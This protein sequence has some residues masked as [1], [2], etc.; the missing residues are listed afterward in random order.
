MIFNS[1]LYRRCNYSVRCNFLL[2]RTTILIY[3]THKR[4]Q[5]AQINKSS[6]HLLLKVLCKN[7]KSSIFWNNALSEICCWKSREKFHPWR[8]FELWEEIFDIFW[9]F[10]CSF[11]FFQRPLLNKATFKNQ[12]LVLLYKYNIRFGSFGVTVSSN[13]RA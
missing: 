6:A 8:N 9:V 1:T 12:V 3:Q 5:H 4:L 7:S 2:Y 11:D 13:L 10:A